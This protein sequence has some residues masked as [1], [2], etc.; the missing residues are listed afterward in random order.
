MGLLPCSVTSP[1]PPGRTSDG[2]K[3]GL[4]TTFSSDR[5]CAAQVLYI[6]ARKHTKL[7]RLWCCLSTATTSFMRLPLI[8]LDSSHIDYFVAP[9]S[10]RNLLYVFNHTSSL[11]TVLLPTGS[12]PE[13]MSGRVGVREQGYQNE[14]GL[15]P[16]IV[17][18]LNHSVYK[19][20]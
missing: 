12:F 11:V 3:E 7:P 4:P 10:S 9:L 14:V 13:N 20:V 5:D 17:V 19:Q 8:G 15:P 1:P 16:H 6:L 2:V 18:V